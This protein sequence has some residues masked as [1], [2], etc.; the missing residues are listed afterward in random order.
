MNINDIIKQSVK[1]PIL[2]KRTLDE[3]TPEQLEAFTAAFAAAAA[4]MEAVHIRQGSKKLVRPN[5][6]RECENLLKRTMRVA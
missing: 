5:N 3:L 6:A 1:T 2:L 4:H